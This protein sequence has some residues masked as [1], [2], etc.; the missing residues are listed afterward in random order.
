MRP[1]KPVRPNN[2]NHR[3]KL[4]YGLVITVLAIFTVR[5][6]YLQ[7]IR[8]EYY[9]TEAL[10]KQLKQYEIQPERGAISAHDGTQTV[11]LVLNE[12]YYTIY[13]DPVYISDRAKAAVAIAGIIGGDA[14]TYEQQM[15]GKNRYEVLAKRVDKDKKQ[16]VLDLKLEGVGSQAQPYRVYPQGSLAAQLLGFVNDEGQG[17]YGLEQA[18]NDD[19][20]GKAGRLKAITDASGVPLAASRGNTK[21]DP[22]PG[23]KITLTIDINM[24]RQAEDILKAGL[25]AAKSGSGSALIMD[26]NTGAIKAMANY[27]SYNPAEFFKVEDQNLFNNANVSSPLEVGSIMKPLTVA[28]ALQ[29]GAIKVSDEYDDPGFFKIDNAVVENVEEVAGAAH[30]TV[31]DILTRSLNTGATWVLM[32]MG[33]GEINEKARVAWHDYMVNHYQLGKLTGIEQGYEAE[34][35]IPDPK[36]G[37]GLN[38]QYANTS[39]GQGLTATPLQM[40]AALSSIINGGTYYRPHLVESVT[41][42]DG[43]TTVKK[44]ESVKTGVISDK[45][46]GEIRSLM[47]AVVNRNH[48]VYKLQTIPAGYSI[49]GKTGTAQITK[50][51]GGYYEDKYNGMFYGF[52][53]GDNPQYV[54]VVR[55]NE[56]KIPGYAGSQAAGPI[57]SNLAVMLINNFNVA[58]KTR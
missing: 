23:K 12:T 39:F 21:T 47:E 19:L 9:R 13:V 38:I 4:M 26:P 36:D 30:R 24:Q 16:K 10:A 35:S 28:A 3:I 11:P 31:T 52:V 53:G 18:L 45:V 1:T 17:K 48:A 55:V 51:G 37:F 56:P 34:G 8:H 43:K 32:Q 6:F 42:K 58:P 27:P 44:P 40:G 7:V 29:Q 50:P 15:S 46:S 14:K 5:L 41:D 57:F 54:I 20:K 49:G 25:D 33:G 2:L 22:I